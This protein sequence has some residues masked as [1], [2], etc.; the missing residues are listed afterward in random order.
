VRAAEG[1]LFDEAEGR[2]G[3]P[4]VCLIGDALWR[5]HFR[6]QAGI[7]GRAIKIDG[8]AHTIVGRMPV[9]W[10]FPENA[11]IWTP[12]RL[13]P[14]DRD[15]TRRGL[16]VV[17]RLRPLRSFESAG[18]ELRALAGR[19]GAEF[20]ETNGGWGFR[21]TPLLEQ[22]TPPGIRAALFLMLAAAGFV[23]LIACAN[24]ANLLL[25]QGVDR[26]R[27]IAT[28]L[29]LGASPR[30]LVR[31]RLV[32]S[33]LLA[34]AGGALGIGL[35]Q[36]GT[37][38]I[39]G[40]VPIEP[41]FW[42]AMETNRRVL[43][44]TLL[45]AVIASVAAGLLP[46]LEATRLDLR[47][48]LQ[49]GGRGAGPGGRA[50]RWGNLLVAAELAACVVLLSGALLMIRSFWA[51]QHDDL[52]FDAEGALS[53]RLTLAGESYREASARALFLDEVVR[54]AHRL[55][56]VEAAAATTS[57]PMSDEVGG[58]WASA[59]YDIEGTALPAAERPSAVVQAGTSEA[60]AALGIALR[61][62]R[63]FHESE[64][65]D[66]AEVAVVS[67]DLAR[68]SWPQGETLG[69]RLRLGGGPWLRVVGVAREV[70]EANSIL[71]IDDKPRGQVYVPYR[72][73]PSSTVMLVIRGREPAALA[74]GLRREVRALDPLLPLYDL[75]TVSEARRRAD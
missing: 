3:G 35:A 67:E 19:L 40:A 33:L 69:R 14:G 56:G 47:G 46:A 29:A 65:A 68:R 10:G 51:R 28:R 39:A 12:L 41:P 55:P 45:G 27:E 32:E 26:R 37:G 60:F 34:V 18:A 73:R 30:R 23:L 21:L 16:D 52:G 63:A 57:L 54:R 6:E 1:R 20:P 71:G 62:G 59:P 5:R 22:L 15:R 7:L 36:W 66:G 48:A 50:R 43:A 61:E 74:D 44:A 53:A 11:E 2:P 49:D 25:A 75:R 8:R 24:V 64:T 58:G 4:A 38:M 17:A 9:G 70:R 42:A 13:D 72:H 31:E